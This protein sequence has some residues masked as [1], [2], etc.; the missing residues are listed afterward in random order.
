MDKKLNEYL[1]T[2]TPI[3]DQFKNYLDKTVIRQG[4]PKGTTLLKSGEKFSQTFFIMSGLIKSRYFD[5]DGK[6]I[7]TRFWKKMRLCYP[8][9]GSG[10]IWN[11]WNFR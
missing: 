7:V 10:K 5:E 6:Q 11:H 9:M 2:L 4:F 1:P 3:C 8:K